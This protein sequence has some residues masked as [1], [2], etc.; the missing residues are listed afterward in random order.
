MKFFIFSHLLFF[1]AISFAIDIIEFDNP[2][3]EQR[4]KH[5]IS[6]LRCPVCQN[7]NLADSGAPLAKDLRNEVF[8]Q[9]NAGKSDDEIIDFLTNRYGDFIIYRP[10]LTP[11]N[12]VLWF[13]PALLLLLGIYILIKNSRRQQVDDFVLSDEE[14]KKLDSILEN[15]DKK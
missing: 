11:V 6:E 12:Y 15:I 5:L 14:Q 4:Y 1:S 13:G 9:I 7:Q 10:R 8:T 2:V 3:Y